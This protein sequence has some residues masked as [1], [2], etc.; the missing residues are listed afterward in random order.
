MS[1]DV[2][3]PTSGRETLAAL[4]VALGDGDG[5][6]PGRIVVVDDRPAPAPPEGRAESRDDLELFARLGLDQ[7]RRTDG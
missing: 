5:P 3:V 6:L 1:Y 4:L 2:V 7:R